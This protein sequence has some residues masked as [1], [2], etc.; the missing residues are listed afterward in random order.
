[1]SMKRLKLAS[2]LMIL[3]LGMWVG[4]SDMVL[5]QSPGLTSEQQAS[6]FTKA[7]QLHKQALQ[8]HEQGK[9]NEA[10]PLAEQVL[11]ILKRVFGDRTSRAE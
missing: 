2:S 4:P 10:V 5:A 8:L 1:M 3:G 7:Q 6:E 9:Y 11:A